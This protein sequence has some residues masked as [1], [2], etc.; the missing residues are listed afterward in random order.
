MVFIFV[1]CVCALFAQE[2]NLLYKE[3]KTFPPSKEK[4]ISIHLCDIDGLESLTVEEFQKVDTLYFYYQ[5]MGTWNF[6]EKELDD[7]IAAIHIIQDDK[8]IQPQTSYRNTIRG[9]RFL[10]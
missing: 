3:K 1:F 9:T 5:P 10:K 2:T 7:D 6:K 4:I 8:T